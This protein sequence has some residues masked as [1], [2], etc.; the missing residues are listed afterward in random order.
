MKKTMFGTKKR[1]IGTM[2]S[3]AIVIAASA[4]VAYAFFGSTG[5]G[6]SQVTV[7]TAPS[8][9]WQVS[10]ATD[11]SSTVIYPGSGAGVL[12]VTITNTSGHSLSLTSVTAAV[13]ANGSGD[14]TQSGSDVPGCA[15]G[16]FTSAARGS[17]RTP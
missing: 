12:D 9:A 10:F 3:V 8:N 17:A 5:S 13:N 2:A 7:G 1:I 4:G 11:P 16:W 14:V 6:S 15:Q